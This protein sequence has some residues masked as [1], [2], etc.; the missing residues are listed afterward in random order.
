MAGETETTGGTA[1]TTEATVELPE[2]TDIAGAVAL[3]G[4][5][6]LGDDT[7]APN[8]NPDTANAQEEGGDT[9]TEREGGEGGDQETETETEQQ[10]QEATTDANGAP[11]FWSAEDKAI[12]DA[13]PAD[14]KAALTP[15]LRK[16][17]HQRIQF[18]NEKVREAAQVREQ[19]VKV[20]QDVVGIVEQGAAWWQANGPA[21]EQAF[22]D[23]WA[24]IDW[25]K[26][27]AD[28]PAEWARL[29]QQ[30]DNEATLLAEAKKRG[31][32]DMATAN[33][34]AKARLQQAKAASTVQL[35]AKLPEHFG[36]A[37]AAKTYEELGAFLSSRGFEPDRI[38]AIHEAAM[39][40]IALEAMLYRKAKAQA[41]TVTRTA[42]TTAK[43]TPTRVQ[44]GP[45]VRATGNRNAEQARQVGERFRKSGGASIADAAE[46]IRLNNL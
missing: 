25:N 39:I 22:G 5:A 45:A 14:V 28:N 6:G 41:S 8:A 43:T 18:V 27:A 17:E 44:P 12:L 19:A 40:E 20:A 33:A 36:P 3:M 24:Q 10:E 13:A 34:N 9:E 31:E 21:F 29:K 37:V 35:A 1:A 15:L 4:E 2:N 38:N 7:E 30:R 26:L 32:A 46:L 11:E 23:K 16:Y 42:N